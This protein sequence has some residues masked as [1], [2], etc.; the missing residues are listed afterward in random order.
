[1]DQQVQL[2]LSSEGLAVLPPRKDWSRSLLPL[3]PSLSLRLKVSLICRPVPHLQGQVDQTSR[4]WA[5][6]R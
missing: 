1:L 6:I 2:H 3:A 5:K 4:F